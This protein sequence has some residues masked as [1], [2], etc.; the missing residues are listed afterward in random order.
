MTRRVTQETA[1]SSPSVPS[2]RDFAP[3]HVPVAHTRGSRQAAEA[4]TG[5]TTMNDWHTD[6]TTDGF[7]HP[8]RES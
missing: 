8:D 1:P 7:Q 2:C 6:F 4:T 3:E 5:G